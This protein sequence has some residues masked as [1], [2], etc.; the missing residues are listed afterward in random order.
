MLSSIG[1]IRPALFA[2]DLFCK[3]LKLEAHEFTIDTFY[4]P[5]GLV[6]G[7]RQGALFYSKKTPS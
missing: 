5:E 6:T 4:F 3:V 1:L 7:P 2:Q